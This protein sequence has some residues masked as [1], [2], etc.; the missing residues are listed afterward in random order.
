[1]I[2]EKTV[3]E[4]IAS[5]SKSG[6]IKTLYETFGNSVNVRIPLSKNI[7]DMPVDDV[8]FSVRASNCLKRTGI[9]KVG[10]V[11]T[12]IEEGRLTNIRNLG[13]KSYIEIKSK[14]LDL[15]YRKLTEA[16][17]IRFFYDMFETNGYTH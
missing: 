9:L 16:E 17:K 10:E 4:L 1:M 3:N 13:K 5:A 7:L 6:L 11:V 2:K 15:G 8:G 14:I 12:A